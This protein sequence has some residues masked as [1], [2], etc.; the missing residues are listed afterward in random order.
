MRVNRIFLILS[1]SSGARVFV[2]VM[3]RRK[4][5]RFSAMPVY[6]VA[7]ARGVIVF[8]ILVSLAAVF[9]NDEEEKPWKPLI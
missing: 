2:P 7:A 3:K 8:A 9:E 6:I 4:S 5:E 1:L